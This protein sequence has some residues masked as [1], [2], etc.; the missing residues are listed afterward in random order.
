MTVVAIVGA[1]V[2]GIT[3]NVLDHTRGCYNP[4]LNEYYGQSGYEVQATECSS[5][6]IGD[7][8]YKGHCYCVQAGNDF[9]FHYNIADSDKYDCNDVLHEYTHWL[10]DST[11]I[12]SVIAIGSVAYCI[13]LCTGGCYNCWRPKP[14]PVESN[15][16][17]YNNA[18]T[19]LID[20]IQ[21]VYVGFDQPQQGKLNP[22][23]GSQYHGNSPV[24]PSYVP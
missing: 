17:P 2:D 6:P 24:N 5:A 16:D 15:P 14:Y 21:T 3:W 10:H 1:L 23:A 7:A 4:Y 22:V 13:F 8:A 19:P 20:D 11:I 18:T 9:C 12:C